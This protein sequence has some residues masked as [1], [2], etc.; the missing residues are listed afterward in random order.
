MKKIA[1]FI[2]SASVTALILCSFNFVSFAEEDTGRKPISVQ[3]KDTSGNV[4]SVSTTDEDD[5]EA[6]DGVIMQLLDGNL[7]FANPTN[8]EEPLARMDVCCEP[9]SPK[10][11][12]AV[13]YH[14]PKNENVCEIFKKT[15]VKCKKCGAIVKESK[16]RKYKSH[17]LGEGQECDNPAFVR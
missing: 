14:F 16:L 2:T 8:Q 11:S 9:N 13:T 7:G 10:K 1:K 3:L 4:F 12:V 6:F 15:V 17:R 5:V